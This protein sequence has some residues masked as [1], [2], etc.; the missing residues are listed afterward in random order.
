MSFDLTAL[1]QTNILV[2]GDVMLDRYIWGDVN[3]I[4]PE[5]P[6]PI[7]Q[8]SKKSENA[9]GAGNVAANLAA[10]ECSV[11][12]I[13][14]CG[15][16]AAGESIKMILHEKGIEN[17]VHV[18]SSRQ[19]ITKTRIMA[20]RQQLLRLDK[21]ELQVLPLE[22]SERLLECF[23]RKLPN[24]QA[25]IIS[26]YGK[27]ML[28]TPDFCEYIIS[29]CRKYDI[30]VLADPKGKDWMRYQGAN[31]VTPNLAEFNLIAESISN[32][33]RNGLKAAAKGIRQRFNLDWLMVTLG[34][35]G[36]F[37]AGPKN[38]S[39]QI[40]VIAQEV[41]DVSGAG[42]T[43]IASLAAGLACGMDFPEAAKL[44]NTASGVA[45]GKIGV[46]PV[47][48][49]ELH[50]AL[51]ITGIGS[52]ATS[53]V[54]IASSDSARIQVRIWR[55]AGIKVVFTNGCFDL[56]H[57]GHL[58]LLH[59]ACALGDRLVVGLNTDAS[60]KRLKGSDRPI[61]PEQGR[62]SLISALSCVDLVVLFNDDTPL[63]L[64]KLLQPD[65]LVKGADYQLDEVIG[66]DM[67]ESY[68]GKVYLAPILEGYSTTEIT[69]KV[70]SV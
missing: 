49:S 58:S 64:I 14:V 15:A 31:C 13:G 17:L 55:K 41:Y 36:M 61:L 52:T 30:F 28:Q 44:A 2:I 66:R 33:K 12:L 10:L 43:V 48:Q 19:T 46:Q 11:A 69:N 4:S 67:V 63:S 47:T 1:T 35:K 53:P 60:V 23:E 57:P 16:D 37:L 50:N 56:L 26:D 9:G 59:Q 42:D 32:R 39:F 6:M 3:R 27:G 51:R 54:K 18:D 25:V 24:C 70:L 20:Q 34:S 29:L 45:V 68:G 22:L 5:A 8:I 62:V 65:I 21:E 38:I 40:P 7:V